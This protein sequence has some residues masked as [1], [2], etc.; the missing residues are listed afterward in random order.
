MPPFA[1]QGM[2]SGIRDAANL[3]WKL[4]LVLGDRAPE[5]LLDTYQEERQP[6]VQHMMKLSMAMGD[7]IT[8]TDPVKAAQRDAVVLAKGTDPDAVPMRMFFP[9]GAGLVRPGP[10]GTMT[11]PVGELMPQGR[12]ADSRTV[13]RFDEVVGRGFILLS[14]VDPDGILSADDK[15]FLHG[16]GGRAVHIRPRGSAPGV[17]DSLTVVDAE[18]VYLPFLAKAG[19]VALLVRP[20]FYVFGASPDGAGLSGLVQDLR[21]RLA[22]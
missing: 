22:G 4:D 11:A 12:V 8:E 21:G 10:D 1:G 14:S 18:D 19:A 17:A 5:A 16:I 7:V 9:I 6:H 20:D 15:E 13:D 2:C 3:A